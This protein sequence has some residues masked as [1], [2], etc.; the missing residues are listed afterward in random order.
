MD[1]AEAGG[2]Q[3]V[4]VAEGGGSGDGGAGFLQLAAEGV[5]VADAGGGV[6]APAAESG[7]RK[8]RV[9]GSVDAGPAVGEA[10]ER[11]AAVPPADESG[12]GL[13]GGGSCTFH[14]REQH[15]V[16]AGERGRR[17]TQQAGGEQAGAGER[18][19]G[20]E[21]DEVE[22]SRR[23]APLEAVVEDEAGDV[24]ILREHRGRAGVAV[25]VGVDRDARPEQPAQLQHLVGLG[26][27]GAA[28]PACEHGGAVA[29]LHQPGDRPRDGGRFAGPAG[30]EVADRDGRASER[31]A[32]A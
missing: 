2:V 25:G 20:V 4:V 14:A 3:A 6:D 8:V 31:P 28:V 13:G 19:A 1:P 23:V 21:E 5:G 30:G 29:G 11:V 16:G 24:G 22:I 32:R 9:F 10:G 17:L 18:A 15:G 7:E 27:G 12:G 26:V